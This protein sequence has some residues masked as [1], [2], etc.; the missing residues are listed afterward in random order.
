M[1]AS[2]SVTPIGY[3]PW[4]LLSL[5]DKGIRFLWARSSLSSGTRLS[6]HLT[7]Q[8]PGQWFSLVTFPDPCSHWATRGSASCGPGLAFHQ[9]QDSLHT[10]HASLQVSD[11]HWLLFPDLCSYWTI[12]GCTF[13][14]VTSSF[15]RDS[16]HT[17]H[18]PPCQCVS[19]IKKFSSLH[20]HCLALLTSRFSLSPWSMFFRPISH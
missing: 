6:S 12:R 4:S 20:S 1:Q 16:F 17:W 3:F 2:R 13:S 19:L 15:S 7:C 11:S 9:G 10:W 8:P 14:K 18:P 5:G